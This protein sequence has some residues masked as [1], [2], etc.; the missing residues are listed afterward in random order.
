MQA[1]EIKNLTKNFK[2]FTLD[3]INLSLPKGYIMGYIGQNG[4]GKTTTIKLIM[5]HLKIDSGSI[6]VF[7]QSYMDD[8]QTYKDM[9]G[10]IPDECMFPTMFTLKDITKLMSSFYSSFDQEKFMKLA[11]KWNLSSTKKIKDYSKGMK[12]KLMFATVL[13]RKT[14]L[15]ILDEPTSGL[16]PVMRSEILELLQEYISDGER[17][18]IF[19]THIVSDLEGI[20]DYLTFIDSGKLIFSDTKDNI[21]E[22]FIIVKGDPKELTSELKRKMIGLKSTAYGFCGL[23]LKSNK[24]LFSSGFAVEVPSIDDIVVY[25]INGIRGA[26]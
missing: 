13:C 17:S 6:S 16:D 10:Y 25:H 23:T 11:E 4:A 3:N 7:G 15:L 22:K 19:S 21:M 12:M 9:I 26:M 1:L 18:V 2:E 24:S 20:A 14:K 5:N 8:E